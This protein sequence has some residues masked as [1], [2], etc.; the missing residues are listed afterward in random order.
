MQIG[1]GFLSVG[2]IPILLDAFPPKERGR[3]VGINSVSWVIGTLIGPV[4]GGFLVLYN[5]RYIFLINVPIGFFGAFYGYYVIKKYKMDLKQKITKLP[6]ISLL[7][8]M[9]PL[10]IFIAFLNIYVM[11]IAIIT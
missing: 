3:A 1:S 11:V 10:I 2:C 6:V 5:W 8:F 7:L 4:L 9:V